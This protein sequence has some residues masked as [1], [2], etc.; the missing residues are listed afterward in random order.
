VYEQRE[1]SKCGRI[2]YIGVV[3]LTKYFE[4]DELEDRIGERCYHTQK[5]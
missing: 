4:G 5:K 3:T 2:I 1:K